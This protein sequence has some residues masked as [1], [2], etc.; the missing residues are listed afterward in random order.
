MTELTM[1]TSDCE[2]FEIQ[3]EA[4]ITFRLKEFKSVIS[5]CETASLPVHLLMERAGRYKKKICLISSIDRQTPGYR[6]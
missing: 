6:N 4:R 5:F 2:L 1:D 3:Q